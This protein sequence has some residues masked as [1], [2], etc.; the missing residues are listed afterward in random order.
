MLDM[1]ADMDAEPSAT[2][3]VHSTATAHIQLPL[4]LTS[5]WSES[6]D[7]S[8][9]L[10]LAR[11]AG[12]LGA[13]RAPAIVPTRMP[14]TLADVEVWVHSQQDAPYTR[15]PEKEKTPA[16]S[17]AHLQ[18]ENGGFSADDLLDPD[19]WM[20]HAPQPRAHDAPTPHPLSPEPMS[21]SLQIICRTLAHSPTHTEALAGCMAAC[22]TVCDA[23]HTSCGVMPTIEHVRVAT[24]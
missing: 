5:T 2:G 11:A 21:A 22:M 7:A 12:M 3:R 1:F 17:H 19:T 4:D 18:D 9:V 6:S 23:V 10:A 15:A 20:A 24:T 13:K 16:P 8:H 14:V